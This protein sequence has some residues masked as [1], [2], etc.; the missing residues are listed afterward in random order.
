MWHPK[1]IFIILIIWTVDKSPMYGKENYENLRQTIFTCDKE[2]PT[3]ELF[4]DSGEFY[5]YKEDISMYKYARVGWKDYSLTKRRAWNLTKWRL[6]SNNVLLH[7]FHP[8]S[9]ALSPLAKN[10]WYQQQIHRHHCN[11]GSQP[12]IF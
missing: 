2:L 12:N 11:T 8:R 4:I 10:H 6:F 7:F 3:L 9:C 5:Q 1:S